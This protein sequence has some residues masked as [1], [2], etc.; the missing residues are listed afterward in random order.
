MTVLRSALCTGCLY[1]QEV[2]LVLI[3]VGRPQG[4]SAAAM[5]MS[6]ENSHDSRGGHM[7]KGTIFQEGFSSNRIPV[8]S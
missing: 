1:A 8:R 7:D 6:M 5:I 4:H 3:S 2:F